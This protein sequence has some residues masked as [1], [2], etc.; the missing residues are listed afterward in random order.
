MNATREPHSYLVINAHKKT[1]EQLRVV[2]NLFG[3]ETPTKIYMYPTN[4][5]ESVYL[6]TDNKM[7]KA[8]VHPRILG[9]S[10]V[11]KDWQRPKE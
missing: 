2:G 6:T 1:D 3:E 9:P 7:G 11:W 8:W 5:Q 4:Q 10:K